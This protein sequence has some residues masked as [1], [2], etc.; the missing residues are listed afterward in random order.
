M[1]E[2]EYTLSLLN[3]HDPSKTISSKTVDIFDKK[4]LGTGYAKFIKSSSVRDSDSGFVKDS[5]FHIQ[6]EI[7][8]VNIQLK[9]VSER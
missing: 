5:H 6:V 2:C 8:S 7:S 4:G 1:Y 3:H 9:G